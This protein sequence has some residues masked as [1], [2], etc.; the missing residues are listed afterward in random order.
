MVYK[1]NAKNLLQRKKTN[2]TVLD[3][4]GTERLLMK[5]IRK[6]QMQ[7]IGHLNRNKG[8]EHLALTGKINGKRSRGRQRMTYLNS[9]NGWVTNKE[10]NNIDFLRVSED[11]NDWRAIITDVCLRPG[12]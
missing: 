4:A 3:D 12:T 1:K 8:L 5:T 10:K 11:R 6:R 2:E 7:F 9:L